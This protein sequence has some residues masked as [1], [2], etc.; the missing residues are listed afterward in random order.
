[1][2][3]LVFNKNN[4]QVDEWKKKIRDSASLQPLQERLDL[5]EKNQGKSFADFSDVEMIQWFLYRKEHLNRQH[6]KSSRTIKEYEREL[7][8]FVEQLVRYSPEIDIDMDY[9]IEVLYS[10]PFPHAILDGTRNGWR[11]EVPMC[12]K[13][14]HTLQQL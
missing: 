2:R 3:N 9:I 4:L 14:V 6:D 1:M 5:A 13:M 11:K 10:N 7:T 8:Q 12:R